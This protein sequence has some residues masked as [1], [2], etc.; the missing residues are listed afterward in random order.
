MAGVGGWE[1]TSLH[2]PSRSSM[3]WVRARIYICTN[4]EWSATNHTD[5][6]H[7]PRPQPPPLAGQRGK[8][9]PLGVEVSQ[10][11]GFTAVFSTTP[12]SLHPSHCPS[13][14]PQQ[15]Q[16]LQTQ[17][18]SLFRAFPNAAGLLAE[19][20]C[21]DFYISVFSGYSP[22]RPAKPLE[23]LES[24]ATKGP[25]VQKQGSVAPSCPS[26]SRQ[27]TRMEVLLQSEAQAQES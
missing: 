9:S 18:C 5:S 20:S 22:K 16:R 21:W 25:Q 26:E 17:Q 3:K 4:S 11:L 14:P 7:C 27:G 23:R 8:S 19:L 12:S 10:G 2:S 6:N 24:S 1:H 15:S 13:T